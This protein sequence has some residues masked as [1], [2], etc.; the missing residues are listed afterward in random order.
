MV[1]FAPEIFRGMMHNFN[2][3]PSILPAS[4]LQQ[5]A[6]GIQNFNNSG[7]SILEIGHRTP[8]FEEV[9][10]TAQTL[11]KRL[12][13]LPQHYE[14]LFLHGGATTQFLQIPMNFLDTHATAVYFNNGIWG[15]KAIEQ[16]QAFGN[17]YVAADG[18]DKKH[19]YIPKN[20]TLSKQAA[21]VHI[22]SNNTVEGTQWHQFPDT[23]LPLVADMS[24]DIFS[25]QLDYSK[26][27]LIYCGAQKNMG[28]AGVTM[29]A[30][31]PQAF[32]T[33]SRPIPTML[34]YQTHINNGSMLNTPPVFAVYVA[35]LTMQWI[36]QEGGL[37]VMEQRA[38][39]RST[40]VYQA[41]DALPAFIPT[42]AKE[43]R[44]HMNIVFT[45][46]N[47][48][49]EE[50]FLQRCKQE[51]MVGVKGYRTV[52]GCRVSLYNAIDMQSVDALVNLLH[53]C[54]DDFLKK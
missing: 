18:S 41:L 45:T 43:D 2:S 36:Q 1:Y 5:A 48:A 32:P 34:H 52:G 29:V 53:Q 38:I 25:R 28:A 42:V 22:T 47:P 50:L 24:S 54:N 7:L 8:L 44:S 11:V 23:D 12:L 30:I 6:A 40:K 17:V 37:A 51:N 20:Y 3:G 49:W 33:I 27:S 13:N 15:K 26:F 39:E 46:Q 14:V 35:M 21:Y 19:A 4:V 9:L 31:D 16:A 10:H